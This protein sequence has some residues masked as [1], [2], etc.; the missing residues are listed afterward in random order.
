MAPSTIPGAGLGIFTGIAL[1]A[2]DV[3]HGTGDIAYPIVDLQY[4]SSSSSDSSVV[5]R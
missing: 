4:H 5:D 2:H 1:K 3:L